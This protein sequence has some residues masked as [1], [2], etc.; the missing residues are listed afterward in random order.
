MLTSP[1]P[2]SIQPPTTAPP[3]TKASQQKTYG[4]TKSLVTTM[5]MALAR[6]N[7][8]VKINACCPGWCKTE[9]GDLGGVP[10]KTS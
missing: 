10:R 5:S 4:F 6:E 8:G 2:N 9:L 3:A 7:P 1:S